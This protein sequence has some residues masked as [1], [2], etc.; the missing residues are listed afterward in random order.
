MR[1]FDGLLHDLSGQHSR[2]NIHLFAERA[3]QK[4]FQAV[5]RQTRRD[6][7]YKLVLRL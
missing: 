4:M 6:R 2:V 5:F 7:I 1:K 3:I